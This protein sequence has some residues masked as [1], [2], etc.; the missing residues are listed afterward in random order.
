M[1]KYILPFL[2][3][4][5]GTLANAQNSV[6]IGTRNPNPKSV[7]DLRAS[8]SQGILVPRLQASDTTT[9]WAGATEKGILFYDTLGAVFRYYNG[10]KWQVIGS[11]G[12]VVEAD[13]KVGIL[14][15]E[16]IPKW[17]TSNSRLETSSLLENSAGNI[18]VGGVADASYKLRVHGK[19]RT[20]GVNEL[21]DAR[22]KKDIVTLDN[23]LAKIGKMRGVK[24][25]WRNTEFPTMGLSKKADIG[26]IA[27]EVEK[28]VPEL[29]DTDDKGYKSVQYSHL[30]ALLVEAIKEQQIQIEQLKA[31]KTT[32]ESRTAVLEKTTATIGDI[33]QRLRFLE[34]TIQDLNA[35]TAK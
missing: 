34:Q 13:P 11:G 5:S 31:D 7:L 16:Y 28:V 29:V 12:S 4:L 14:S 10:S 19:V 8:G 1:K 3:I 9:F 6:G 25:N 26:L 24:Y 15:D 27:Q 33:Q 23:S 17:S 30:V 2:L 18:G 20:A 22:L 35:K 32:L 21:S